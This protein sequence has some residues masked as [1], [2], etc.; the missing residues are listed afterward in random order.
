MD[1]YP[2]I[3]HLLI[4]SMGMKDGVYKLID[5]IPNFDIPVKLQ[6]SLHGTNDEDRKGIVRHT[7]MNIEKLLEAGEAFYKATV[8]TTGKR[9]PVDL[10]YMGAKENPCNI[11][12]ENAKWF[13]GINTKTFTLK[14]V[15]INLTKNK[16]WSDIVPAS[17]EELENFASLVKKYNSKL[18]VVTP[19]NGASDVCGTIGVDKN[20]AISKLTL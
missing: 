9:F 14:L 12:E 11:E 19:N 16:E 10:G 7:Q 2:E 4:S 17:P 20:K 5:A 6:L 8:K 15:K 1:A 13:A 18:K 3:D